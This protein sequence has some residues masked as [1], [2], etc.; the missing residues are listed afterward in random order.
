MPGIGLIEKVVMVKG[1]ER[2]LCQ[3]FSKISWD[4]PNA[5]CIARVNDPSRQTLAGK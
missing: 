5:E 3:T 2:N 1:K 4:D